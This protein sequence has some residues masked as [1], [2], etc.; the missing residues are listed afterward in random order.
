MSEKGITTLKELEMNLRKWIAVLPD[1]QV[2]LRVTDQVWS[3]D[4]MFHKYLMFDW[5]G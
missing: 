5:S 1:T 3:K 2:I 4:F